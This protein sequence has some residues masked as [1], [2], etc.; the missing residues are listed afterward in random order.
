MKTLVQKSPPRRVKRRNVSFLIWKDFWTSGIVCHCGGGAK[1][2]GRV[3]RKE[4]DFKKV[5]P[6]LTEK[7]V[8]G[9]AGSVV[10]KIRKPADGL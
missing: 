1:V 10:Q 3:K 5:S 7:A 8:T 2:S 4:S 9:S 6:I